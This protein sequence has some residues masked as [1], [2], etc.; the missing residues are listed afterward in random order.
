[1]QR[2]Y[3][4]VTTPMPVAPEE[5][6]TIIRCNCKSGCKTNQCTCKKNGL[7]CGA[8]C[9]KCEDNCENREEMFD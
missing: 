3:V 7:N 2:K 4:P 1:M 5:L 8:G 9:I 6:V